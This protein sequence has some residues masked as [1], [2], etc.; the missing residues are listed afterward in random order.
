MVQNYRWESQDAPAG[1]ARPAIVCMSAR[2]VAVS[3]DSSLATKL[4]PGVLSVVAG[5]VDVRARRQAIEVRERSFDIRPSV[6]H[7]GLDATGL[8][9][10][11]VT[12]T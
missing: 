9:D 6:E 5:S 11:R 10:R 7:E 12:R 1:P 2:A 4:L 3:V 8:D